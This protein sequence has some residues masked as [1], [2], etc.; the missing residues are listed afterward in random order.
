MDYRHRAP[1]EQCIRPPAP[2]RTEDVVSRTPPQLTAG[3]H[4]MFVHVLARELE[5]AFDRRDAVGFHDALRALTQAARA[6]RR[7]P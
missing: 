3:A 7:P 1:A 5:R 6:R 4:E 2:S